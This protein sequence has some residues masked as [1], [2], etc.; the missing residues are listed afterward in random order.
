MFGRVRKKSAAPS[1]SV[2]S[3]LLPHVTSPTPPMSLPET[4]LTCGVKTTFVP[5]ANSRCHA[6]PLYVASASGGPSGL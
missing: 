5:E 6:L 2:L 1:S 3:G 4:G